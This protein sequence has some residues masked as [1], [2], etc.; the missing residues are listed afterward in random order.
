MELS[1]NTKPASKLFP[2]KKKKRSRKRQEEMK[3][4]S[5]GRLLHS[6]YHLMQTRISNKRDR[7]LYSIL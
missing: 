6:C 5:N 2:Q 3:I 7:R 1:L 4:R